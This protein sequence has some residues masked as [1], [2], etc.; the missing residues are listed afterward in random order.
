[1]CSPPNLTCQSQ[2]DYIYEDL[3]PRVLM[4]QADNKSPK[5]LTQVRLQYS[6]IVLVSMSTQI[7][8][9]PTPEALNDP[10]IGP[11]KLSQP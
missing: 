10:P 8:H 1:M 9:S 3:V 7:Q 5:Q 6:L 11:A 2:H 4:C